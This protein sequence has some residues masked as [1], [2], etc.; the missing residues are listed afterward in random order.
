M[1]KRILF[2]KTKIKEPRQPW[3]WR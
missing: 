2:S 3:R 1:E